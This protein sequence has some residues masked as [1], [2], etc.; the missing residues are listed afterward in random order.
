MGLPVSEMSSWRTGSK[1]LFLYAG[2]IVSTAALQTSCAG[3]PVG[4]LSGPEKPPE[5]TEAPAILVLMPD[6]LSAQATLKGLRDELEEDYDLIA[7]FVQASTTPED[8]AQAVSKLKPRAFVLMN[9]P[10]V[11]LF[12]RYQQAF[13]NQASVPAVALLTSFLRESSRGIRNLTGI[14][15]EVPLVTSLVNLRALLKEPLRR[16]GVVHRPSFR[17]FLQEQQQ[18]AVEEGFRLVRAE[19]SGSGTASVRSAIEKLRK[20]DRVDAIW[21]LNDNVL[22][23]RL[24]LLRAWLPSLRR[25]ETPVVVNVGTLLS[26]KT[27]FGTFG[28]LPDHRAL[29]GQAGALMTMVAER[30]WNTRNVQLEYPVSVEKVLDLD[31]ARRHLQIEE[32]QLAGVRVID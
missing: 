22:L 27:T 15:Y 21:V 9:N 19:V 3:T 29:G 23:S 30:G 5:R 17:Q 25:N 12:R 28:V 24:M 2:A 11:R 6:S 26:R 31:F 13:P 10:T 1:P 7:R 18:L 20:D 16:V 32:A 8:V 4:G 14:I